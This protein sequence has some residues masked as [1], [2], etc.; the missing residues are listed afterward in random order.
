MFWL[1][2]VRIKTTRF[3]DRTNT[4]TY[5]SLIPQ[6][7][8][9]SFAMWCP[10]KRTSRSSILHRQLYAQ[11]LS[12]DQLSSWSDFEIL[13][14]WRSL[15]QWKRSCPGQEKSS[16]SG[17][18][19]LKALWR[20]TDGENWRDGVFIPANLLRHI[21][22]LRFRSNYLHQQIRPHILSISV[23][24][25]SR[26]GSNCRHRHSFGDFQSCRYEVWPCGE[27]DED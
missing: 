18:F 19:N 24:P 25:I 26:F 6:E 27:C 11:R 15:E 4:A 1:W 21:L 10:K 7:D 14:C 17:P 16:C 22:L 2:C 23:F 13:V 20:S 5:W 12:E 8:C 9:R 3:L